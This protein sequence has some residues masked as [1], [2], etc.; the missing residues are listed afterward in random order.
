MNGD[1]SKRNVAEA[2]LYFISLAEI[3]DAVSLSAD[4]VDR[5]LIREDIS[6]REITL[7]KEAT[8]AGVEFYDRFQ[9]AGYRGMYN[10]NYAELKRLKGM[11]DLR[12]S[13]LDFMRKDELAGNV[14]RLAMTEGRIKKDQP[15]GQTELENLAHDVGRKVRQTMIE[16]TGIRPEDLPI[17]PD[18]RTVKKALKSTDRGFSEIDDVA[19]ERLA[20][21]RSTTESD[22]AIRLAASG[23]VPDCPECLASST[24]SHFGSAHCTSG[25][26]AAGGAIAHCSCDYCSRM[27]MAMTETTRKSLRSNSASPGSS[28]EWTVR[29]PWSR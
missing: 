10:Q 9:N 3:M 29:Q 20:A 21:L 7:S 16:E 15:R 28:R 2:Q 22:E 8:R 25:A 14:F 17:G 6:D 1:V 11:P 26:L 19:K 12:R 18:I 24:Y 5:I 13:L 4:S 27:E 23:I